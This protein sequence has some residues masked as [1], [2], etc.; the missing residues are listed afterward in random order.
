MDQVVERR[1]KGL[2]YTLF[3][4]QK[5]AYEMRISDWSSDVCSSDLGRLARLAAAP[6]IASSRKRLAT[7]RV[8]RDRCRAWANAGPTRQRYP[9]C[10]SAH[11]GERRPSLRRAAPEMP[12]RHPYSAPH[13]IG[14]ATSRAKMVKYGE[15]EVVALTIQKNRNSR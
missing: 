14:R 15:S 6:S 10:R 12:A 7:V 9:Q 3:F 13:Q 1:L 8:R 4:K 2:V 11:R 5:T